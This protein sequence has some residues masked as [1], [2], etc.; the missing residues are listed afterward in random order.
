VHR[1]LTAAVAGHPV[2][3]SSSLRRGLIE[4]RGLRLVVSSKGLGSVKTSTIA[5]VLQDRA[6][7]RL[8][9]HAGR[10]PVRNFVKDAVWVALSRV[11]GLGLVPE[12][13]KVARLGPTGGQWLPTKGDEIKVCA[14]PSYL[15]GNTDG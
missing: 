13:F 3:D 12:T 1:W 10:S 9:G 14:T 5:E 8:L 11:M 7:L 2:P 15:L 6:A 4:A